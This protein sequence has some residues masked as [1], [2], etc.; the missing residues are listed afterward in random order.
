MIAY[1]HADT[2]LPFLWESSAQP[3]ARWHADG[4][5]PV[6][7]FSETPDGAWCEFLRHEEIDEPSDLEGVRRAM[8]A[9]EMP[10]DG[11]AE[12]SLAADVLSGGPESYNACRDE[13]R[14]LRAAGAAGLSATSAASVP[15][16]ASGWR[17]DGGMKRGPIRRE[18]TIALFGRRPDLTGWA[19]CA[20]GRPGADLLGRVHHFE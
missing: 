4:D 17:V 12:P 2:R 10:E 15:G 7:Y 6:Q 16:T 8:W 9:V 5:G 20:A 11:L 3:A 19:A 14:R 1:R 13:A 18:R